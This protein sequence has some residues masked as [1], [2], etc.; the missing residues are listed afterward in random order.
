MFFNKLDDR[1]DIVFRIFQEAQQQFHHTVSAA[2]S[3]AV[4]GSIQKVYAVTYSFNGVGE[5]ELLVIVSMYADLFTV[6]LADAFEDLGYAGYL[7]PGQ[8]E[9]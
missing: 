3:H 9:P 1:V 8:K 7:L 2:S 6:L 4:V 5:G